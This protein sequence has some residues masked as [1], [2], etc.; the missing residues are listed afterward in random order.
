MG[1][2][3]GGGVKGIT[4]FGGSLFSGFIRSHKVLTSPLGVDSVQGVVT[5]GTLRYLLPSRSV[6]S[7]S[8]DGNG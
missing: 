4:T 3:G 2:G 8:E 1:R 5:I 7:K 6:P